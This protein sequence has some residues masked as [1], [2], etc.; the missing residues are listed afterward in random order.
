MTLVEILQT[1]V[2]RWYVV[3]LAVLSAAVIGVGWF[4]DSGCYSTATT[5]SFTL[6]MRAF[7]LP[8]S[9]R[10]DESVIAFAGAIASEI[11]EGRAPATYA[12]NAAPLYGVGVRQ[13]VLVAMP[14]SGGQ[15]SSMYSRADIEIQIVGAT[16]EWVADTQGKTIE[17]VLELSR[18]R[19]SASFTSPEG[20]ITASVVPLTGSIQHISP[21]RTEQA[22]SV[23]SLLAA[24]ILLGGW[25]AV[26]VDRQL[27]MLRPRRRRVVLSRLIE[28]WRS[29][30]G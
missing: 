25:A 11:N 3:L 28:N 19:Q 4:R 29:A 18:D 2:Q 7:L 27:S 21:S 30:G 9:G 8:E 12:S 17:R 5:V 22:M 16:R 20:Y 6:P 14:N 13:G 24:A 15:W 1:M 26:E 10:S 23:L